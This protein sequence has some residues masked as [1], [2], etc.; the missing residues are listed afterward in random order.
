MRPP[1]GDGFGL[2]SDNDQIWRN[3]FVDDTH[4]LRSIAFLSEVFEY[5]KG[6]SVVGIVTHGEIINA[7]YEAVGE[8]SYQPLNTQVVPM[9]IE[10]VQ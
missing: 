7:M 9:L 6:S 5:L 10:L 2:I 3:D 8:S 4:I 1:G